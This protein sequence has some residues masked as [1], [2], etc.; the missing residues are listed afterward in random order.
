MSAVASPLRILGIDPGSRWTGFGVIDYHRDRSALVAQGRIGASAGTMPE[1]L[2]KILEGLGEVIRGYAPQEIAL[3][4]T[5]V[6]R[7]NPAS[8]LV[9]GQARGA[10]LCAAGMARLSVAEYSPSQ[11]KQAVAG[12]GRADK[13]QVQQMVK[14]L[15]N[16]SGRV[17]ADAADALAVA[18]AHAH[19]RGTQLRT[20]VVFTPRGG[21]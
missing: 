4:E 3:E 21:A 10:A 5:F 8:A 18:I 16:A 9:L 11:V 20:G 13:L 12:S 19:V 6:N 17:S 14:M 1:R 15:L 2:L 7:V